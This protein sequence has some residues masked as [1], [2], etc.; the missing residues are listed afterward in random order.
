[1]KPKNIKE[2]KALVERYESIKLKEIKKHWQML[3]YPGYKTAHILTGFHDT[4]T[5][6]LCRA[7]HN[8][9]YDQH[10]CSRC[11]Y[12]FIEGCHRRN[13]QET[14]YAIWGAESPKELLSA[15]R[16]RAKHLRKTYPQY[17]E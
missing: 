10:N 17:L 8:K 4:M 7:T 12:E 2:F 9:V 3:D 15:F 1:M 11:V 6:S 14:Y 16:A 13:N 5:C